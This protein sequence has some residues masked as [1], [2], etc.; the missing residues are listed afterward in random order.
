MGR[1]ATRKIGDYIDILTDYHSNG[2]YETLRDNV[3]L[4]QEKSHAAYI[5]TL[6]FERS[7]FIHELLYVDEH[8]YNFLEKSKA[9]TDDI[10]INKIANAGSIYILPNMD[11]P[12]TCGMNL[13]LVRFKGTVNQRYMYYRM[14][15]SE[16]YIKSFAH[17]TSTKTITKQEIRDIEL[18]IHLDCVEQ[19]CIANILTNLDRKIALNYRINAELE[20]TARTVYDYIF[21]Q[22]E[23]AKPQR[24]DQKL[25]FQRGV[26]PGREAYSELKSETHIVPFIRVSDLGQTPAVFITE[27][28]ANSSYCLPNDVMVAFD[29][30][31]GKMAIGMEGSYSTGIRKIKAKD[32]DYNDALIY[33]IFCSEE[34]QKTIAKYAVGSNILHAA[35]AIEHLTFPWDKDKVDRFNEQAKPMYQIIVK[36]IQQNKALAEQRDFLLPLLMNGQVTVAIE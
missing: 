32:T 9:Y 16:D 15:Y 33:F 2:S 20:R 24:L 27:T 5:R 21:L 29:G 22:G 12:V 23:Q 34:I 31:V 7:D 3:S 17:G 6:N 1:I 28:A 19:D 35:S 18:P 10:F 36:N 30:S 14:K 11:M 25:K 13:F 8:A 26:E 4:V